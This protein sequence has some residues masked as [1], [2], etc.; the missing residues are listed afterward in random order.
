[1]PLFSYRVINI[2]KEIEDGEL[3]AKTIEDVE[4]NLRMRGVRILNIK[5]KPK[6]NLQFLSD[7]FSELS[8]RPL[9][10]KKV[11]I[12][13]RQIAI[14]IE[15]EPLNNI[16][17]IMEEENNDPKY[18][19]IIGDIRREVE[20]GQPLYKAL[21]THE[22]SFSKSVISLVQA[23]EKSGELKEILE[24]IADYQEKMADAKDKMQSAMIYPA[25]LSIAACGL[26][27]LMF[28]F[29]IPSFQSLFENLQVDL[30][31]ITKILIF[32]GDFISRN[33]FVLAFLS[34]TAVGAFIYMS[35]NAEFKEKF[36]KISLKIPIFGELLRH[37][38]WYKVL[39]TLSLLIRGGFRVDEGLNMAKDVTNNVI[40][41]RF[42]QQA[43]MNFE[44][45]H[46]LSYSIKN[47]SE[48]PNTHYQLISAG[49][50]SGHLE[51]MLLKSADISR[52]KIDFTLK[53]IEDLAT[54]VITLFIGAVV[55]F[56]VLAVVLP[57]FELTSAF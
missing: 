7:K 27:F 29:I 34:I 1:M 25:F 23:G 50:K 9:D 14:L 41:K 12:F 20:E 36:D 37:T 11:S 35:Q 42:L 56:F 10:D 31:L 57:I 6:S 49:E 4:K 46:S 30:P 22:R 24:R 33:I 8:K 54:P 51:E 45:G 2:D 15:T 18:T 40:Y 16:L 3:E 26:L 43:T 38:I 55:F 5:E 52:K 44:A 13:C 39:V 53:R 17:K 48:L 28:F 21:L 19:E 47:F 32:T